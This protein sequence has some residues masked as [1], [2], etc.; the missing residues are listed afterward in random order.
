MKLTRW[1]IV[2]LGMMAFVAIV[3]V[4]PPLVGNSQDGNDTPGLVEDLRVGQD[5]GR[6]RIVQK[7]TRIL[8]TNFTRR[9]Q[10]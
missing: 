8:K 3:A 10:N 2:I 1:P 4:V 5:A 6:T 9:S 7:L